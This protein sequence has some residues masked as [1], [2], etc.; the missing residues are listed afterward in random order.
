MPSYDYVHSEAYSLNK[1][2][3]AATI[4]TSRD[5]TKLNEIMGFMKDKNP[6]IRYWGA[7]GCLILGAEAMPAKKLL[8]DL[9]GDENPDVRITAAEALCNLGASKIALPIL[10]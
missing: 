10:T 5:Q 6:T 9:L 1:I 4:S 2:L 3:E 7:T 8:V